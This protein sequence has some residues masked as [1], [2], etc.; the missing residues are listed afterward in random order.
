MENEK[1]I[2]K[3]IENGNEGI[4]WDLIK[5]KKIRATEICSDGNTLLH[6][7]VLFGNESSIK[8]LLDLGANPVIRNKD[9]KTPLELAKS[10]GGEIA[11]GMSFQLDEHLRT[12][13]VR[14]AF[15][16]TFITRLVLGGGQIH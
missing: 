1:E 10:I 13:V 9:G 12:E 2:L 6:H 16:P 7:A 14:T 5:T 4:I 8:A 15:N 3:E 11:D